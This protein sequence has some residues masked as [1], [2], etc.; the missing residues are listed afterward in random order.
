MKRFFLITC[1]CCLIASCGNKNGGNNKVSD[2]KNYPTYDTTDKPDHI[3]DSVSDGDM[4][5]GGNLRN[6]VDDHSTGD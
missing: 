3:N 4:R 1:A 2:N 6:N 5:S